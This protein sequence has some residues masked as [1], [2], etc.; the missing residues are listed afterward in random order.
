MGAEFFASMSKSTEPP[1]FCL[2]QEIICCFEVKF[3]CVCMSMLCFGNSDLKSVLCRYYNMVWYFLI[4]V[5]LAVS[6][7]FFFL[8]YFCISLNVSLN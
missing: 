1:V 3:H 4:I 5:I 7:F 8:G 6:N 2:N